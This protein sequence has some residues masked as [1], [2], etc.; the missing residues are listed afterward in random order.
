MEK[1]ET[2]SVAAPEIS[3]AN[4]RLTRDQPAAAFLGDMLH[5]AIQKRQ[6]DHE[7]SDEGM[8]PALPAVARP[9]AGI[10]TEDMTLPLSAGC[11]FFPWIGLEF[12]PGRHDAHPRRQ[13][14]LKSPC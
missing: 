5:L 6:S 9:Q 7:G 11:W 1:T 12:R 10:S 8:V 13:E 14:R 2:P 3:P 4:L